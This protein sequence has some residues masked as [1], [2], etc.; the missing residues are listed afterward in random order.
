MRLDSSLAVPI[1][2]KINQKSLQRW[3]LPLYITLLFVALLIF[4]CFNNILPA[5]EDL[6]E[7]FTDATKLLNGQLPY[8]DFQLEYPPLALLFF[9]PPAWISS[10]FGP[11]D[12][13]RYHLI[14]HGE[15]FV[16]AAATLWVVAAIWPKVYPQVN[17]ASLIYR[18]GL[19][20]FG[21][22]IFCLYLLQR[23]DIGAALI[24]TLAIYAF[25]SE[26]PI[27]TGLLLAL[28]TWV[29]LYPAIILP[30][31]LIYYW[32]TRRDWRNALRLAV[33]F[34][35]VNLFIL[36]ATLAVVPLRYLITFLSYQA[37]REIQTESIY[38]S[39]I[40]VART[41][42][43]TKATVIHDY[44]SFNFL[45]PWS[46]PLSGVATLLVIAGLLALYGLAWWRLGNA[47][48]ES[49]LFKILQITALLIFWFILA[50]KVLSPQY[51]IW[52]LPFLS[53]WRGFKVWVF[54]LIL[55]LSFLPFPFWLGD[56][57]NFEPFPYTVLLIRNFL[58][59]LI[60]GQL[61]REFLRSQPAE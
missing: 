23:F 29:K 59:L 53:F 34:G 17:T 14:F 13:S 55:V 9:V 25:I 27:L 30:V 16:L 3:I 51:L 4:N 15:C 38:A 60:F 6:K 47:Q 1:S 61:L 41:L 20:A 57:I 56:L 37:Q 24:T 35:L 8:R 58:L 42:G 44:G 48:K 7:Y 46:V 19:Y 28:G 43:L 40:A 11:P 18:L 49:Q 2:E 50:N 36:G 45:S 12:L 10:W 32:R 39:I 54:L 22:I 33:S 26:R 31:L 52:L 5:A 21:C